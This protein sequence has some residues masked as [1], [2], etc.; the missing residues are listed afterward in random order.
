MKQGQ[1]LLHGVP[2][3]GLGEIQQ[4]HHFKVQLPQQIGEVVHV[5]N[6]CFQLWVV[7]ICEVTNQKSHFVC[8]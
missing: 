4:R 6:G 3:L 2:H 1:E 7:S 5:N 8:S